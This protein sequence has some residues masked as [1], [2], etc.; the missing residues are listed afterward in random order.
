M[1]TSCSSLQGIRSGPDALL[2][3]MPSRIFCT[4]SSLTTRLSMG[5]HIP[6][7]FDLDP[8]CPG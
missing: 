8:P 6:K 7:F 3:F 5:V 4:P 1:A 2:G